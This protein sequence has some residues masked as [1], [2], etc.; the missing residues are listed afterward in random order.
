MELNNL[1][2]PA[3]SRKK[4]KRLGRGDASGHGG[5]STRGHKGHRARSGGKGSRGFEGGQMP[6]QRRLPKRGFA[7]PFR[8]ELE[9][10]NIKD[11]GRFPAGTVVDPPLLKESGLIKKE[12]NRIKVLG[13]GNLAHPLIIKAHQFSQKAKSRIETAG[14]KAE[15]I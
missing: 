1:K 10:I 5:T 6:L 15:V 7:N 14:G 4:K 11:L 3:G 13:E 8:Q 12:Q 9:I 2:P